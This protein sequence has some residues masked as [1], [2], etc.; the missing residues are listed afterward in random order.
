MMTRYVEM[1]PIEQLK[2]HP[3]NP[4]KDLGDLTELAESIRQNGIMQNLTVVRGH[5]MTKDE[6]VAAARAEGADKASAEASY[7]PE[8][9]E[10][11]DGFTVVIGNRR[12][13]AAKLA[14]LET[15][16]CVISDMDHK[17]QIATMLE[18]NMQRSD[19]TLYEQAQGF[20]MM[21]ELG[22]TPKEIGEKTGFS[23][24]TVN[25]R[26]KMAELDKKTFQQA[27]GKQITMDDLDRLGQLKS[28]KERN[29]LLK[30]FG[31]NNF[32]WKL[33]RAIK[34]Q[35]AVELKPKAHAMLRDAGVEKIPDKESNQIYNGGYQRLYND[36]CEL[37][38][39]DGKRNFVPKVKPEDGK[40]FYLESET[41]I[42]FYVKLKKKKAEP[43]R[44]SEE[45]LEEEKRIALA[46][47]TAQRATET[48]RE[49]RMAYA[50]K[51]K[52]TPGNAMEMLQ[53]A[54]IAA[55]CMAVDY[56]DPDETLEEMSG[57][58]DE[59]NIPKRVTGI[60]KYIH[61]LP[62]SRWP[63]LILL[64]FE[65]DAGDADGYVD[66]A[67]YRMPIWKENKRVDFSYQWL[68][69]FGYRMSTEEEEMKYGTHQVFQTEM[70]AKKNDQA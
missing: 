5:R 65:G 53:W 63:E 47:K 24:T 64:F 20:Q 46:W 10:V 50:K 2:H 55:G 69:H 48:A 52:V 36:R 23:E 59:Y 12:M 26:L 54:I 11:S 19:L 60:F 13:E 8:C 21:M 16:P 51:M 68:K 61:S 6:W 15:L 40:L 41:D 25:R 17:T 37:D 4:R 32:E 30:E 9:A 45:E 42:E 31:E 58:K 62:Q 49:L 1:I 66:G 70:E 57:M 28:V 27:V 22:F 7:D 44:K 56:H 38:K 34:V 29:A 14:G 39:W 35:K 3:E 33:N 43:V 67:K 18:E